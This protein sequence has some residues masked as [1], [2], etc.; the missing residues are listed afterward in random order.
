MKFPRFHTTNGAFRM[1]HWLLISIVLYT[2]AS[3]LA[4]FEVMPQIQTI[5]WK[6]GHET[7]AAFLGYWIDRSMFR[8][9]IDPDSVPM[10][11][12]RRAII[13]GCTMLAVA[14]GL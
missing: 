12:I 9:R 6:L 5:S 2:M 7:I 14:M 11:Q 3:G 10:L 8:Q 4:H 1:F 13:I